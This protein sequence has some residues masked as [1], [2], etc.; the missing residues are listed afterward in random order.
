MSKE[1][2]MLGA[3]LM[4]T[5]EGKDCRLS[6]VTADIE[7]E[8]TNLFE[9]H[10]RD[11]IARRREQLG[12]E[13]EMHLEIWQRKVTTDQYEW[14]SYESVLSRQSEWGKKNL[15]CLMMRHGNGDPAMMPNDMVMRLI[16]RIFLDPD[17]KQELF[18]WAEGN[19]ESNGKAKPLGLYWRSIAQGRPTAPAASAA[20]SATT[21]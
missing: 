2:E 20:V 14:T 17:K 11:K 7:I 10:A 1:S 16:D 13:Y 3:S 4:F 19:P 15:L 18:W 8:Y 21:S 5:F 12:D 9:M 6:P